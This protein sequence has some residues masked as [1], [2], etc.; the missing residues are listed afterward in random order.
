MREGGG[1]IAHCAGER[2]RKRKKRRRRTEMT[3]ENCIYIIVCFIFIIYKSFRCLF[4]VQARRW[5][6][7]FLVSFTTTRLQS[8]T[9]LLIL[10][11]FQTLLYVGLPRLLCTAPSRSIYTCPRHRIRLASDVAHHHHHQPH[12]LQPLMTEKATETIHPPL[13]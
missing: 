6:S 13:P 11:A 5:P 3:A 9:S 7:L 10:D 12:L 1:R 2:K 8:S 4:G